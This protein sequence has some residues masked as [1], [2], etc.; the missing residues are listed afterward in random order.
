MMVSGGT[1]LSGKG[2]IPGGS[3][4][5]RMAGAISTREA[6]VDNWTARAPPMEDPTITSG[7]NASTAS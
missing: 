7:R 5:M 1:G 3:Q 4:R 6:L 2:P